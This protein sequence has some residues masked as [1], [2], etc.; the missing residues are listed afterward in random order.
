MAEAWLADDPDPATRDEL[1]R[2]IAGLPGTEAELL[3]AAMVGLAQTTARYWL[4]TGGAIDRDAGARLAAQLAWRGLG[5]FPKAESPR[6]PTAPGPPA[7]A[8]LG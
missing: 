3:G 7:P 8:P 4:Q 5:G 2:L 1:S 6:G